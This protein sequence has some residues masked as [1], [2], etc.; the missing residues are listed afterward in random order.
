[1]GGTFDPIHYGHLVAAEEARAQFGLDKVL[2]MPT[3]RP[4]YKETDQ[5]ITREERYLMV[6]IATAANPAFGVSRLEVDR[7][8]PT[9]TIDTVKALRREYGAE[10]EI[11]FITGADAVLKIT[12]WKDHERL[13]DFCR[14]IAVTRPGYDLDR[15]ATLP[16]E[17]ESLPEITVIEV[18]ALAISST[19]LR[20]R[21]REGRSVRYLMPG[22][23]ANYIYKSGFYS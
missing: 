6:V 12:D 21:I 13:A 5:D 11:F 9:H 14:F 20:R 15:F 2:F 22:P 17:K 19:D 1:M 23:V 10:T 8:G 4:E 16:R 18:P 3:G 7:E